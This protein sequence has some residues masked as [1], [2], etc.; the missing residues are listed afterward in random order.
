M[1]YLFCKVFISYS[2]WCFLDLQKYPTFIWMNDT[3]G[4]TFVALQIKIT[5]Y[6]KRESNIVHMHSKFSNI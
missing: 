3:T 6:T 1:F 4:E 2:A 5:L